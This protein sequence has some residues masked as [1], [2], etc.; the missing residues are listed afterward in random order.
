MT[1]TQK[2]EIKEAVKE[3][4][5]SELKPLYVERQKHYE[6]HMFIRELMKFTEALKSNSIMVIV[7]LTILGVFGVVGTGVAFWIKSHF[8]H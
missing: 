8:K 5:D 1:P 2:N 4:I 6:E 7:K 3:V